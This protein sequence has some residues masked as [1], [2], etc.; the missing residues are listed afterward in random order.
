M[1]DIIEH[2]RRL[3]KNRPDNWYELSTLERRKAAGLPPQ[4]AIRG[5]DE[6]D[7][8]RRAVRVIKDHMESTGQPHPVTRSRWRCYPLTLAILIL[9]DMVDDFEERWERRPPGSR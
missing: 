1:S 2:A 4:L 3:L 6:C 5:L 9:E 8:M 7:G